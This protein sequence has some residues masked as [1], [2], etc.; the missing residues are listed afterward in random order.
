VIK[1]KDRG[2]CNLP[3][4]GPR[5]VVV[6]W[7]VWGGKGK[8]GCGGEGHTHG[9]S[10]DATKLN[11]PGESKRRLNEIGQGTRTA[12]GVLMQQRNQGGRGGGGGGM[13]VEL[14]GTCKPVGNQKPEGRKGRRMADSV[15]GITNLSSGKRLL[16]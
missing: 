9:I 16:A 14:P 11:N 6:K 8:R 5:G 7:G 13:M 15:R 10:L 1:E 4:Q 2:G 12:C 3:I